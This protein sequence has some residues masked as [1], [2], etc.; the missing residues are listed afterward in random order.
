VTI[1]PS[2]I[3]ACLI[4]KQPRT[5]LIPSYKRNTIKKLSLMQQS[6]ISHRT[7]T[8]MCHANTYY[9]RYLT[10]DCFLSPNPS[11]NPIFLPQHG[12][13]K[14]LVPFVSAIVSNTS[15]ASLL[16]LTVVKFSLIRTDLVD[17]GRGAIPRATTS[18]QRTFGVTV[19]GNQDLTH[20]NPMILSN[21]HESRICKKRSIGTSEWTIS[22]NYNPSLPTPLQKVML[23]K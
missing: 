12:L 8:I 2:Q 3:Q 9:S 15:I 6:M 5:K 14:R 22:L 1:A 17:F 23:W 11:S 21:F 16:S 7:S 10:S 20:T 19:P 13:M 4:S 18:Q